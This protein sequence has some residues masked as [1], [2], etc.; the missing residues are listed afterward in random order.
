MEFTN[1]QYHTIADYRPICEN[2]SSTSQYRL[3]KFLMTEINCEPA[4]AKV[5]ALADIQA[6]LLV[7]AV[8]SDCSRLMIDVRSA[9]PYFNFILCKLFL[10]DS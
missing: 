5:S 7:Y 4:L 6:C 8:S 10:T 1:Q 9:F 3:Y 2:A